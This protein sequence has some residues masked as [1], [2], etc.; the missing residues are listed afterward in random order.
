MHFFAQKFAKTAM[1]IVPLHRSSKKAPHAHRTF[2]ALPS[3]TRACVA[4][5]SPAGVPVALKRVKKEQDFSRLNKNNFGY[6]K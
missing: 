2:I 4:A 1:F 6:E 5:M 3:H